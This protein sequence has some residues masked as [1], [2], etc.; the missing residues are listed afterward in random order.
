MLANVSLEVTCCKYEKLEGKNSTV[1]AS[2][3][4]QVEW[5]PRVSGEVVRFS[6]Q[7]D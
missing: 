5:L 3:F 6:K 7:A 1:V 4:A 2:F